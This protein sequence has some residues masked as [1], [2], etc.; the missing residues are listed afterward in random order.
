MTRIYAISLLVTFA[1]G[2]CAATSAESETAAT[3]LA[4]CGQWR[5]ISYSRNDSPQTVRQI[6]GSNAARTGYGCP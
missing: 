6:V 4:V 1:I 2:G 5:A 3:Y